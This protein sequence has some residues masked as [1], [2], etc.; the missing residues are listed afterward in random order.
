MKKKKFI[1]INL[2]NF[3]LTPY[4]SNY[5]N[6]YD[7]DYDVA[8]WDRSFL[9][10]SIQGSINTFRFTTKRYSDSE[11][12]IIKLFK[13]FRFSS[14]AKKIL[15]NN[16][17]DGVIFLQTTIAVFLSSFLKK[18]YPH[19]YIVDIRD[20]SFEHF[21][22]FR[23]LE[24]KAINNSFFSTISSIGYKK[25]LPPFDY[26]LVHNYHP[27]S[28]DIKNAFFTRNRDNKSINISFIGLIRF[29]D[30]NKKIINYFK[31]DC[32]FTLSFIGKNALELKEY[33]DKN[34]I[35]NVYLYDY[36]DSN[37][38]L[39]FYSK[40]DIIM[41]LYGNNTPLLDYAVSNKLYYSAS[42]YMPILVCPNTFMEELS[43]Q[44]KLG[45]SLDMADKENINRLYEWFVGIDR[46]AFKKE[47]D[48]FIAKVE[49]DMSHF[50]A[51]VKSFYEKG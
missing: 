15:K 8:Y 32:R 13:Y 36:F 4:F 37:R 1:F 28:N 2:T 43:K 44:F 7:I 3:Y 31:N 14:F 40:T 12:K 38:T 35:N 21:R 18:R 29:M 51:A 26:V 5:V 17:Y 50:F 47:C 30:Q 33:I 34:D 41:N 23:H 45:F 6:G 20:Y 10:E 48:A 11:S 19:K 22:L 24:K 39:D 49:A 46:A 42:L 9:A 25:F 16:H 27:I